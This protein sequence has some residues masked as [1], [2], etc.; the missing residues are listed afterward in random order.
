MNTDSK[1]SNGKMTKAIPS[2]EEFAGL[3]PATLDEDGH[4][5]AEM[6][7]LAAKGLPGAEDLDIDQLLNRLDEM[8][9]DVE[10]IIF[11]QENY[12]QF[13]L[14]PDQYHNSQAYFCVVC[15]ITVLKT[16]YGIDYN[17]KW[18]QLTPSMEIPPDFEKNAD[19]QF[20]HAIIDGPGGTCGSLPVFFVAIGRRIGFPLKLVKAM[21][22]L[23]MRWD[24][25]DGEWLP[26][27]ACP[28]EYAGEVFN[29][30][31]S[32]PDVHCVSDEEYRTE[33]PIPIPEEY[34]KS[35][36]Y[37]RSL[38]PSEELSGFLAARGR[39]LEYNGRICEAITVYKA[40]C[41]LAPHNIIRRH[42][43]L[44]LKKLWRC[45]YQSFVE[46]PV[47]QRTS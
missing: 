34:L 42:Y 43:Y 14:N 6:N 17:P 31:A 24:D 32:G 1:K 36:I 30:E 4:D 28:M 33:W 19:D 2:L 7:L 29:I 13:L 9:A 44:R 37:L 18:E 10:R 5:I 3:N 21:R 47:T 27:D 41:R 26:T 39:C 35:D 23:Y 20:I 15:M 40:A 8:A 46:I 38:T 12:D 16:K 25:P 22:H 11:L 45:Q